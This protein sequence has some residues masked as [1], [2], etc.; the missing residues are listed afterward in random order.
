VPATSVYFRSGVLHMHALEF[1]VGEG[2]NIVVVPGITTPAASF[3]T[4]AERLAAMEG[5]GAVYV[6]DTRGR[7]LS[8]KSGFGTHRCGDY[9][10]DVIALIDHLGL[11]DPV[12]VGHSMGARVVAAARV[13]FPGCAAATVLIDPPM[14]GPGKAAY[15]IPL[16]RMITGVRSA[17]AGQGRAQARVDYPAWSEAQVAERGDWLGTCDDMALV[18]SFA[19]FH[20]EAFESV[21]QILAQPALL[22]VGGESLVVPREQSEL[23]S[24]L[25]PAA[26][27]VVI[28]GA[29]H[30]VPW[31]N[32]EDTYAAIETFLRTLS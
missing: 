22:L 11:H 21:W 2:R 10:D 6:L 3:A 9:A 15:P 28:A 8:Q 32:P 4:G 25:N 14:S 12:L 18:E 17:R 27:K 26:S 20:L 13:K 23:L 29:G 16:E 30:M 24:S 31:D 5:V 7:G 19:W 1:A